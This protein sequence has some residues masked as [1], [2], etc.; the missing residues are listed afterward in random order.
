M[1]PSLVQATDKGKASAVN[2]AV[3]RVQTPYTLLLDD[4]TRLGGARLPTSL[5]AADGFDAVAFHVL[6]D[7]RNREGSHG[8]TFLGHL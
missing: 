2:Y 8:N 6:P 4:D 7:R 1:C 3:Y 5:L